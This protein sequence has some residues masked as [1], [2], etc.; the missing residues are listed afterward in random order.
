MFALIESCPEQ[1]PRSGWVGSFASLAIHSFLI[2]AALAFTR[3][4]AADAVREPRPTPM[5]WETVPAERVPAPPVGMIRDPAPILEPGAVP[6]LV[7]PVITPPDLPP[8]GASA[9]SDP[10]VGDPFP[11]APVQASGRPGLPGVDAAPRDV[12]A[13][14][15]LPVLVSHPEPRYP[16]ALRQAGI[17][18]RVMIETVLDTLGCAEPALTRVILGANDRFD[19]EALNVVLG[20]RYRPARVDGHPVRVRVQV[21]VNFSIR[22]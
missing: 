21:P 18:G 1:P 2:S 11:G 10:D 7:A 22:R 3:H 19:R 13:V 16:D 5:I 12:R 4:V 9:I 6:D 14:E 8:P 20:S 17:E 15:E